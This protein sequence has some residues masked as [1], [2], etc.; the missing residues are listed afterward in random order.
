MPSEKY[1]QLIGQS[2]KDC[3]IPI[4]LILIKESSF[5]CFIIQ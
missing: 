4:F 3:P 5:I 1:L 2:K